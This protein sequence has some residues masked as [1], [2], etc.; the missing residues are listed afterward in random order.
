MIL[1]N[2][3]R[4]RKV[5]SIDLQN[6]TKNGLISSTVPSYR[7]KGLTSLFNTAN[8]VFMSSRGNWSYSFSNYVFRIWMA[9]KKEGGGCQSHNCRK[10]A[11]QT[12]TIELI[13]RYLIEQA[14]RR[15]SSIL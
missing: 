15:I 1:R 4:S 3:F 8:T 9:L 13:S 11:S 7:Y 12:Y 14:I 6:Q 2:T 10:R 5:R